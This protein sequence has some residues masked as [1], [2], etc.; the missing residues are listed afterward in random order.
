VPQLEE[1]NSA[2]SAFSVATGKCQ[3]G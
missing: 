2:I 3:A 1:G